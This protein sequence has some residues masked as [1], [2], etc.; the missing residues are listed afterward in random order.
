MRSS[1]DELARCPKSMRFGPCG[2]VRHD[3]ACEVDGQP[4]PFLDA[5]QLDLLEQAAS[6][7]H[8]TP[9][10]VDLPIPAVCTV[11]MRGEGWQLE[12]RQFEW[13]SVEGLPLN[14]EY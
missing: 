2:G 6:S 1:V 4:C 11:A 10:P 9:I 13:R 12:V 8:R 14:V 7:L 5:T 3:G